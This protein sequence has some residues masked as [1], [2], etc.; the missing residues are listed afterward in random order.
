[1]FTGA[2][3]GIIID[4]LIGMCMNPYHLPVAEGVFKPSV[5]VFVS[6]NI[7]TASRIIVFIGELVEDF[8]IFSYRDACDEGISFG[9][10][11]NLT[12][13]VLGGTPKDS[14]NALILANPG[15]Q[16]WHNASGSLMTIESFRCR[17]R[18]SAVVRERPMS[19][20]N[21]VEGNTSLAEHTKY[22]FEKLLLPSLPLGAKIDIIGLSEGGFAALMYLKQN[23]E[24]CLHPESWALLTDLFLGTFWWPHISCI[25]LVN[26]EQMANVDFNLAELKD[27]KSFASFVRDRGRAWVLSNNPLGTREVGL[28]THGCNCYS[29]GEDKKIS[30]MVS[31]GLAHIMT[32]ANLM[33]QIPSL[34]EDIV[35]VDGEPN[36]NGEVISAMLGMDINKSPDEDKMPD[37]GILGKLEGF[38]GGLAL[39]SSIV[40]LSG[41]VTGD[42]ATGADKN[43]ESIDLGDEITGGDTSDGEN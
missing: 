38:V 28:G 23:C 39:E 29:S 5:P 12:K 14:P 6:D 22:I 9:S 35:V 1:M 30:C 7:S 19:L 11:L 20:R 27:P 17:A 40:T 36:P 41:A 43:N 26:P 31:R 25:G 8:G 13:A 4:R 21:A 37:T 3:R 34:A 24:H 18:P 2:I 32:W 16:I 33:H 10:V 15:Q 42:N